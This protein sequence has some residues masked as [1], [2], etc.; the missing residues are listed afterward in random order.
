MYEIQRCGRNLL[1]ISK[2]IAPHLIKR[3]EPDDAGR[4]EEPDPRSSPESSRKL[5]EAVAAGDD[6]VSWR[7]ITD[8]RPLGASSSLQDQVTAADTIGSTAACLVDPESNPSACPL[9]PVPKQHG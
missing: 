6:S 9:A 5:S 7:K 2:T 4:M 1:P 3:K 8:G